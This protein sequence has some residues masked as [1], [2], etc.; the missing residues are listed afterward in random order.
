M[1]T[2]EGSERP[3]GRDAWRLRE[4]AANAAQALE[5]ANKAMEEI[6]RVAGGLMAHERQCTERWLAAREASDR[7]AVRL[8]QQ[9][10][11]ASAHRGVVYEK[12]DSIDGKI[13]SALVGIAIT[14]V[15][16]IGGLFFYIATQH[17]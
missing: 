4:V 8:D 6:N 2:A 12:F 9:D 15:T 17:H 14:C 13:I 1:M 16:S 7:V 11:T 10:L 5:R 3:D